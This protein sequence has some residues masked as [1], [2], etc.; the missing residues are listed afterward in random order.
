MT[1]LFTIKVANSNIDIQVSFDR[2]EQ[3]EQISILQLSDTLIPDT[4]KTYPIKDMSRLMERGIYY[5]K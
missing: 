5:H 3:V 4:I 1:N 2:F